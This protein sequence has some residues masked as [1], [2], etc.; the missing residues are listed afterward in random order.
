MP[1]HTGQIGQKFGD[2][3]ARG[4]VV[5][6]VVRAFAV[7]ALQVDEQVLVEARPVIEQQVFAVV[8]KLLLNGTV[9][10]FVIGIHFRT[11]GIGMARQPCCSKRLA[12]SVA[13]KI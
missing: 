11:S 6:S 4:Q 7:V 13:V 3:L 10:A 8:H 9:E 1:P 12:W 5:Q 2:E